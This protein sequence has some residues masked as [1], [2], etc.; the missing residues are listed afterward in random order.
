MTF[1]FTDG[2]PHCARS[3][4]F[5]NFVGVTLAAGWT[6]RDF[7]HAVNV[8]QRA[9]GPVATAKLL[10]R[11]FNTTDPT[12]VPAYAFGI[13]IAALAAEMAQGRAHRIRKPKQEAQQ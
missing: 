5:D 2:S 11:L 6:R 13:V 10:L 12:R 9:F 1:R 4:Q 7:T 3:E 8:H